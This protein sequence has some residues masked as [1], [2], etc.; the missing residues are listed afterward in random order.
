MNPSRFKAGGALTD[1][2]ADL[3]IERQADVEVLSCV[4]NMDYLFIIEPRQQGKTSLLSHLAYHP[5]LYDAV[6]VY[7]DMTTLNRLNETIWYQSLCK[8]ILRQLLK[9]I[10][11]NQQP[12]IPQ[13]SAS[14]KDFLE[15]VANF[16][17]GAGQNILIALDEIGAATPSWITNFFA[18]LRAVYSLRAFN[19]AYKHLTFLLV[20]TFHPRDLI[21]DKDISPF[22]IAHRVRLADF[23]LVQ[24]RELVDKGGWAKEQGDV[25]AERIYYWVDGQPYLTQWL[26]SYLKPDALPVDVDLGIERLRREDE[27][28]L[29]PLMNRLYRLENS[30]QY[31]RRILSGECIKFNPREDREQARLELLGIIKEST[32][33]CCRI[34]NRLYEH[35]LTENK[36]LTFTNP[37]EPIPLS[38]ESSPTFR[39]A[40]MPGLPPQLNLDLQFV[41]RSYEIFENGGTLSALF[42][43]NRINLWRE[44]LPFARSAAELVL[45]T[46]DY[47]LPK[48]DSTGE[49]ALVL[50]LYVLRD[51]TAQE[52]A[53]YAQLSE[54]IS[55]IIANMITTP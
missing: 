32:R 6:L 29:P 13:S 46:I 52:D 41:L 22:N 16:A 7:I 9:F 48:F 34:R 12:A 24:V 36:T 50:F 47:L 25:L 28:H 26:C 11:R 21:K 40:E 49:N 38:T 2:H 23:T 54:L 33:G 10:P 3:Y 14:L 17:V 55:S 27:N 1:D 18:I 4:R 30:C 51:H 15:E 45:A 5:A 44:G 37:G 19:A 53:R 43:D 39:S 42:R 35:V 8:D 20:G 31:V